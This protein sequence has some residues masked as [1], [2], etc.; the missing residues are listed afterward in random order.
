MSKRTLLSPILLL[1]VFILPAFGQTGYAFRAAAR[2]PLALGFAA[3]PTEREQDGLNG[4]VRRVRT[5][6]AKLSNKNGKLVEGQRVT[7]EV[8]A[9][10]IKGAKIEN[11]YY[12][13]PGA[14]VTGKEVY[15]YDDKGNIIEMTLQDDKGTLLSK[16]TYTY[17]F[18]QFGNWTKMTTSVAVIEN[19]KITFEPTE[20]T[21]RTISY[22]LDE[23][24]LAKMNQPAATPATANPATSG[25]ASGTTN[26]NPSN[27]NTAAANNNASNNKASMPATNGQPATSAP[28][29]PVAQTTSPS[30]NS[31]PSSTAS[32]PVVKT[33]SP[34]SDKPASSS[35]E[36]PNSVASNNKP[37]ESKSSEES[38]AKPIIKPLLK[39]VSGGVL[40]GKALDL[41]K[42]TYPLTARNARIMGAVVVEVVI[43][44]NG[45][46]ISAKAV[47]G[48]VLLQQAAVQAAYQAKFSPTLVSNQP[49]KVVGTI[50]YN[51]A[52]GQ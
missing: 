1:L 38:G 14:A 13:V 25:P 40:N 6:T 3:G 27:A 9:Y 8:A 26:A 29:K 44:V 22:Y 30:N 28:S 15:K 23:A 17:E 16:E 21:Y 11:A 2:G 12:P 47:S 50:S 18:D 49:V 32:A 39:P 51:F 37:V 31:S 33:N 41:P 42:P 7:L 24:T 35:N 4:P 36:Q 46:V 5:E 19:G 52:L 43:D 48:P 45:K 20:V 10:D 34:V